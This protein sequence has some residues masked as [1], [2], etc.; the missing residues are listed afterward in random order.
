MCDINDLNSKDIRQ[1]KT[2]ALPR[3]DAGIYCLLSIDIE[4]SNQY[5]LFFIISR[6]QVK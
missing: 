4:E 1:V 3:F 5:L 2:K 6:G